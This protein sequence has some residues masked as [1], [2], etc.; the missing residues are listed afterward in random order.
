MLKRLRLFV[1]DS[2]SIVLSKLPRVCFYLQYML[3]VVLAVCI[4]VLDG[5]YVLFLSPWEELPMRPTYFN[6]NKQ[7]R[8][9]YIIVLYRNIE[10]K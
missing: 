7:N 1:T 9:A 5:V 2:V 8:A 4:V 3:S 6:E 10:L